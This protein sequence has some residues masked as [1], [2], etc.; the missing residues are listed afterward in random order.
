[1]NVKS[2]M[3][4]ISLLFAQGHVPRSTHADKSFSLRKKCRIML[5][6]TI[7][8]PPSAIEILWAEFCERQYD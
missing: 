6:S 7:S 1:M 2:L 5:A 3:K 8:N 4:L